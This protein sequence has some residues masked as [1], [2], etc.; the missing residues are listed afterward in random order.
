MGTEVRLDFSREFAVAR[1]NFQ[2]KMTASNFRFA[3]A[4]TL[5]EMAQKSQAAVRADLP[6]KFI[7]RRPWIANGIRIKTATKSGLWSAIYSLDSGGRRPFMTRQEFGG[8]K[9]PEDG[10]HIAV[11]WKSV[12]P[13][14]SKALIPQNM[15]PKALLGSAKPV[16]NEKGTVET[17][18]QSGVRREFKRNGVVR[19][20]WVSVSSSF[21]TL[22]V[23]GKRAGIQWILIKKG[24]KYV[25]AWLLIDKTKIKKTQFLLVPTVRTINNNLYGAMTRNMYEAIKPKGSR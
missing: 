17:H 6:R 1:R 10:E 13:R 18:R 14:G 9:A 22:K 24:N 7:V 5:T 20:V 25:P 2:Q 16:T 21:K 4:K 19:R 12:F 15:K 23:T 8:I 11:P 3:M